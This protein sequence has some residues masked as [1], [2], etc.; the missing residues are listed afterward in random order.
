MNRIAGRRLPV[1]QFALLLSLVALGATRPPTEDD[2]DVALLPPDADNVEIHQVELVNGVMQ[3]DHP[4]IMYKEDFVTEDFDP[5]KNATSP[6][7]HKKHRRT[8]HH[9]AEPQ[10]ENEGEKILFDVLPD[11]PIVLKDDL[12]AVPVSNLEAT[13]LVTPVKEQW[14]R[15]LPK[16]YHSRQRRS[17]QW[18]GLITGYSYNSH[19]PLQ[20]LYYFPRLPVPGKKPNLQGGNRGSQSNRIPNG[21]M[22]NSRTIL[23]VDL[24]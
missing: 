11:K 9:H 2:S 5:S 21:G 22:F 12:E 8:H 6:G 17:P 3:E 7:H 14:L 10:P 24:T 15:K 20:T 16:K 19:L 18:N 13:Q 4:V 23:T 1:L